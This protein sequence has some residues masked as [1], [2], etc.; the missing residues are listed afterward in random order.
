M[1]INEDRPTV[2]YNVDNCRKRWV[3][4]ALR[5]AR[6]EW[7]FLMCGGIC[8]TSKWPPPHKRSQDLHLNAGRAT[9]EAIKRV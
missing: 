9:L 1:S 7:R 5:K 3:L 2:H 8:M 6:A 4:R